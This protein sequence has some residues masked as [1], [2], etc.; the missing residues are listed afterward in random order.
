[1]HGTAVLVKHYKPVRTFFSTD[2]LR[3]KPRTVAFVFKSF[4]K[5]AEVTKPQLPYPDVT[6]FMPPSYEDVEE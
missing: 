4:H 5:K 6:T 2:V 1:V 3:I